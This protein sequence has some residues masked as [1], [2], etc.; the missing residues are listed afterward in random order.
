M[1]FEDGAR[2]VQY[3]SKDT[4]R[5][6][7]SQNYKFIETNTQPTI[8]ETMDPSTD[9]HNRGPGTE[10]IPAPAHNM[11]SAGPHKRELCGE[12]NPSSQKMREV[13]IDY[14]Q[15]EDP[16]SDTDEDEDSMI[17]IQ[18]MIYD[19]A[20]NAATNDAPVN[21][22]QVK[23]SADWVEW[24]HVIHRELEHLRDMGTWEIVDKP[25]D[26]I[27]IANK[28][29]FVKKTDLMGEIVKHKARLVIKGCLQ[30]PRFDFNKTYSPIVRIKTIQI[31]L[32][33]VPSLNLRL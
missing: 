16:F 4:W 11:S 12:V 21:L 14:K 18:F 29:V 20:Y 32:A 1:G 28:W 2:T 25:S 30:H 10:T 17:S 27:P 8:D 24:E 3:Y 19:E 6:L 22:K 13:Y 5:I 31:L 23:N 7:T 15:L 26:A 9:R 33:M